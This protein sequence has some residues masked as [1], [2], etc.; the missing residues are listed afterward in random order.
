MRRNAPSTAPYNSAFTLSS[1]A[2]SSGNEPVCSFE[3]SSVPFALNSKHP[4]PAG[5]SVRDLIFCLYDVSN[6]A[7]KLTA[8]GS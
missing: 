5:T 1:I 2:F 6:L 8:F 3:Y 7:A 4:P